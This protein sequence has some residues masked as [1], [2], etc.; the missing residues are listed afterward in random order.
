MHGDDF[1]VSGTEEHL[2]I[3]ED[4]FRSKY[5]TKIRG[6]IGPDSDDLKSIVMLNRVIEW[7]EIGINMEADQ[8]HVELILK[9]LDMEDCRGSD[10][11]GSQVTLDEND[12]KMVP[13]RLLSSDRWRQGVISWQPTALICSLRARTY[14]EGC[15]DHVLAIGRCSRRWRST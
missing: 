2:K 12:E 7:S 6:I 1:V 15:L 9:H 11:V 4:K 14:A 10:I 13:K 3:V 8:R 5:L